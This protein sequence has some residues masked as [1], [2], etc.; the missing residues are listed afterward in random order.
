MRRVLSVGLTC[1]L[2]LIALPSLVGAQQMPPQPPPGGGVGTM[3]LPCGE[4]CGGGGGE[5]TQAP[6][7]ELWAPW[8][9]PSQQYPLIKVHFCDNVALNSGTRSILVNGV[10]YTYDFDY[11]A[12]NSYECDP[13]TGQAASSN[14]TSVPLNVGSNTLQASICDN[15][16]NCATETFTI[17]RVGPG[18][19]IL[20]L[21]NFNGDNRDRSLCLTAGAGEAAGLACGDLFVTHELPAYETMGR[22]R[23]L[24]LFYSSATAAP[25]PAVAVQV[26]QPAGID[27]PA[28]VYAELRINGVTR[29]S[30]TFSS[31]GAG[32]ARQIVLAY[33]AKDDTS[34]VYPFKVIVRNQYP[35]PYE[36][37]LT[38]NLMVVNRSWSEFGAGWSL[39]GIEQVVRAPGNAILWLG[40]DGSAAVYNQVASNTY[41]RAPGAFRDTLR[42]DPLTGTYTR[43]LRH[44]I[45]VVYSLDGRHLRTLNRTGQSTE[46]TWDS[47]AGTR[48]WRLTAITVPPRTT[49]TTYTLAYSGPQRYIDWISDPA[50]R[51]LDLAVNTHLYSG[52][53][54]SSLILDPDLDGVAYS[55]DAI[56]RM[57]GRKNRRDHWTTYSYTGQLH[58]D[59]VRVPLSSAAADT[60][61]TTFRWW[62]EQGLAFATAGGTLSGVNPSLVD[63]RAYGPRRGV[64]DDVFF[65]VDRFGA[66]L[67][68]TDPLGNV[69]TVT[70]G[71]AAV[72]ALPTE[73]RYA[74]GR[75]VRMR[76]NARGNL[77]E[78]R[79]STSHLGV[80]GQPTAVTRWTYKSPNTLDAPDSV[81]DPENI[82]SRFSYNTWG[83]LSEAFAADGHRTSFEYVPAGDPRWLTGLVRAV[84]EH[85]VTAVDSAGV[86]AVADRRSAF[87]FNSL[88]NVLTDTTP[89]GRVTTRVRDGRQRVVDVY[90]PNGARTTLAYDDM[91]RR[92]STTQYVEA[93]ALLTTTYGYDQDLLDRITDPRGVVR[94]F[95]H[96]MAGRDTAEA[97][98]FGRQDRRW[99]NASGAVDSVRSRFFQYM[100]GYSGQK[101]RH[102]YDAAGRI[103]RTAWPARTPLAADSNLFTYD[104]MGRMLTA[105]RVGTT[106]QPG[107]RLSRTYFANG[108]V[109][110]DSQSNAIRL[111]YGYDRAGRRTWYRVGTGGSQADSIWYRY[112]PLHGTL[113]TIKV[114]WRGTSPIRDSVSFAW[115][116]LGRRSKV[117]YS[118]GATVSLF[119]DADGFSR[120]VCGKQPSGQAQTRAFDFTTYHS[121]VDSAGHIRRTTQSVPTAR[122]VDCASNSA[123]TMSYTY[124]LRGQLLTEF[125][126]SQTTTHQYDGSGNRTRRLYQAENRLMTMAA[127]HN[128]LES[129]QDQNSLSSGITYTYDPA[130]NRTGENPLS[131]AFGLRTIYYDGLGRT[132]G[133]NEYACV[134]E[135]CSTSDPLNEPYACGYDALGRLVFACERGAVRLGYDGDNVIRT[136]TDTDGLG[137]TIVHGPGT[138]DPLMAFSLTDGLRWYY[139]TDGQGRQFA[140]SDREGYDQSANGRYT[141]AN[142]GGKYAG[143]TANAASFGATRNSNPDM[144][145][146]SF[147]RNRFYDQATGRWTQE[148]P[149]GVAGGLNLYAYVGNN[150]TTF[151]DPFGLCPP[152]DEDYSD[153]SPGSSEWYAGRLARGEGSS[154]LNNVGGA[155]ASCGESFACTSVLAVA[156][157][158]GNAIT[159]VANALK[160]A[161]SAVGNVSVN[162]GSGT[163]ARIAGRLWTGGG[164]RPIQAQRGLGETIGRISSDGTRV[165]R[166]PQV[167]VSGPNAGQRAANLIRK[168][169]NG[170][171]EANTHLVIPN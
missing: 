120:L 90:A 11:G 3:G 114:R 13:V 4:E 49:G 7:I 80:A 155:L 93:G 52:K 95:H 79:D 86:S 122:A 74:D 85:Q 128:R 106:T 44:G 157:P 14:T 145:R 54:A 57:T 63:T 69:T 34:G 125:N 91:N 100:P 97:D 137:I 156:A 131:G 83:L 148:D 40:G 59:S 42:L 33:D 142:H 168:G 149:I 84:T 108:S 124:D 67:Q 104:V 96:D 18:K 160:T 53:Y 81:I 130:G 163:E 36:D 61:I 98:D 153:C 118:N 113:D 43:T 73:V 154:V 23:A 31:F 110:T 38:G 133:T 139:A 47:A 10:D 171:E 119:Y 151:T 129:W 99:F 29:A 82:R 143:G 138:D 105:Q 15:A 27:M 127:G 136:S 107:E 158:V 50:G 147:F 55:Y 144:Y 28:G 165:Y 16:G 116:E 102:V 167:K 26:S 115:D 39:A 6:I 65:T 21:R 71:D 35:A 22:A 17:T 56:G 9:Q 152:E 51:P 103:L 41:V 140:V 126:G 162:V 141:A 121:W 169:A 12:G 19:P 78:T 117:R 66:P 1:L 150:P 45:Q 5:D 159:R 60:A 8:G 58:V 134:F 92:T 64:A 77:E 68:T 89:T 170:A 25:R 37:S 135:P 75:I 20:A 76:W 164:S 46:M 24:T 48:P 2:A 62:D 101:V 72:P 161:G 30:G 132:S 146:L 88:G 166:A 109:R 32:E 111:T 70:R 87:G 112:H 123:A 94:R